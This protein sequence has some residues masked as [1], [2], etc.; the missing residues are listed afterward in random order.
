MKIRVKTVVVMMDTVSVGD[1]IGQGTAWAA[2][3][4]QAYIDMGLQE[5]FNDSN[6]VMMYG[7]IRIQPLTYQGDIGSINNGVSM[8]R[9]QSRKVSDMLEMKLL[10]GH[11]DKMVFIMIGSEEFKEEVRKE[12][13]QEPLYFSLFPM[14]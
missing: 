4:S 12:L 10:E 3:I 5:Q 13:E 14:T 7:D 11:S 6:D 8:A 2:L 9:I 1:C